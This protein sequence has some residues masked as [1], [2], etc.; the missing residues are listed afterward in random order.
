MSRI[1]ELLTKGKPNRKKPVIAEARS[2]FYQTLFRKLLAQIPAELKT[3]PQSFA[4][5]K[6]LGTAVNNLDEPN[7]AMIAKHIKGFAA[8]IHHQ[9][10]EFHKAHMETMRLK[11]AAENETDNDQINIAKAH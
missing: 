7:A 11:A 9:E 1:R 2:G 3:N 6:L 10:V 4:L 8:Y 5:V